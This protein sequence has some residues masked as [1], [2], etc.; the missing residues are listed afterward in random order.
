MNPADG[1]AKTPWQLLIEGDQED[2]LEIMRREISDESSPR[3]NLAYA[4]A[5]MWTCKYEC[6]L[7]HFTGVIEKSGDMGRFRMQGE[8]VYALLG[9]A[10][11][12]LDDH[13]TAVETWRLG[14]EAPYAN[15]GVP[16]QTAMLMVAASLLNPSVCSISEP[17]EILSRRVED[18]RVHGWLKPLAKFAIRKMNAEELMCEIEKDMQQRIARTGTDSSKY[19]KWV[20]LFYEALFLKPQDRRGTKDI[21]KRLQSLTSGENFR[22]LSSGDLWHLARRGEFHI[23]KYQALVTESEG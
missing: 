10:H 4:V 5:L 14:I 19:V 8:H 7:Q 6:V 3:K 9:A 18:V 13:S 20:M 17:T 1:K 21:N 15:F 23:A 16:L 12:C 2:A 22:V 11:W